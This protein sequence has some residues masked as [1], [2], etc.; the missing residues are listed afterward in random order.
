MIDEDSSV[1]K[2][3]FCGQKWD[4]MLPHAKDAGICLGCGKLVSDF[5]NK[6]WLDIDKAHRASPLPVCGIYNDSQLNSWGKEIPIVHQFNL[7]RWLRYSAVVLAFT[8]LFPS[9]VHG[10]TTPSTSQVKIIDK[11][12]VKKS[13]PA[14]LVERNIIRGTVVKLQSDSTKLPLPNTDVIINHQ[15]IKLHTK[16][17]SLG[18][19]KIDIT[20]KINALPDSLTLAFSHK[21]FPGK[22]T[23]ISKHDLNPLNIT[24]SNL[25]NKGYP[26][27]Q[28]TVSY[29]SFYAA[30]P[31]EADQMKPDTNKSKSWW[32]K[33]WKK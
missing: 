30:P 27:T 13:V 31:R 14:K 32:Q 9:L 33:L 16:T 2:P 28:K 1:P 24:L 15:S 11:S 23:V 19:F 25:K 18:R 26:V 5:R 4:D 29:E 20:N 12:G 22:D 6:S 17:D 21:D 10:Q 7:T 8:N 3:L